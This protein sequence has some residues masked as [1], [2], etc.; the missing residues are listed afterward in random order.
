M[1]SQYP[2]GFRY[3]T[4]P[5]N[6]DV[7][8][9]SGLGEIVDYTVRILSGAGDAIIN[10]FAISGVS[11][12]CS[13]V[14][15]LSLGANEAAISFSGDSTAGTTI[16]VIINSQG[17]S[18]VSFHDP[19]RDTIPVAIDN[20]MPTGS[21]NVGL[22]EKLIN[23]SFAAITGA[24]QNGRLSLNAG[25]PSTGNSHSLSGNCTVSGDLNVSGNSDVAGSSIFE[26][27]VAVGK[28]I[29]ADTKA[30]LELSSTTL[31]FLPPRMT[32]T[33]RNA[34][35]S[36]ATGSVI[37]NS[38]TNLLNHYNGSAWLAVGAVAAGASETKA[39]YDALGGTQTVTILNGLITSWVTS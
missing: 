17:V 24:T 11:G 39:F 30:I 10:W 8:G 1:A 29:P 13:G 20:M 33:Q 6:L 26:G 21:T 32:N 14:S 15:G 12:A 7:T 19:A 25:H 9:V 28:I 27:S 31:A 2:V 34:I 35:S 23:K 5:L 22:S 4:N 38:T 16:P 3:G 37:Y 36:P 18:Q